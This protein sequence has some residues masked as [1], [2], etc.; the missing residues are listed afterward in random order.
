MNQNWTPDRLPEL[1]RKL[2]YEILFPEAL[3]KGALHGEGT[4]ELE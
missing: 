3:V 4:F 2:Q 1:I